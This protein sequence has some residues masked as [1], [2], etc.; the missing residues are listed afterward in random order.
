MKFGENS[1]LSFY[2]A[3]MGDPAMGPGA[4][5]HCASAFEDRLAAGD[6]TSRDSTRIA[7][8]VITAGVTLARFDASGFHG[9]RTVRISL[10]Y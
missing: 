10:G 7:D 3:P 6:I 8:D 9:P 5:P 4:Y 1:L 2:F